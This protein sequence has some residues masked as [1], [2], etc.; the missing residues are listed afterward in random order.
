MTNCSLIAASLLVFSTIACGGAPDATQ[1]GGEPQPSTDSQEPT[2]TSTQALGKETEKEKG[3][4]VSGT[5]SNVAAD[6][7]TP[8][9]N[10]PYHATGTGGSIWT[11]TWNGTTTYTA[12]YRVDP[13]TG[14]ITGHLVETFT[15]TS[16]KKKGKI[17][18]DD[19]VTLDASTGL[20]HIETRILGGTRDFEDSRGRVTFDGPYDLTTGTG[21]GTYAGFWHH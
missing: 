17:F 15:G 18:F 11:G 4:V 21:S 14:N 9:A 5:W 10:D 6:N 2:E 16:G 7:L 1:H 20:V 19:A 8:D 13:A 3:T 12:D